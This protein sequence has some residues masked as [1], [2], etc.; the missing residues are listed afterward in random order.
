MEYKEFIK[1]LQKSIFHLYYYLFYNHNPSQLSEF[2]L[3]LLDIIQLFSIN[4]NERVIIIFITY[5]IHIFGMMI[6]KYF[7]IL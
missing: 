5:R 1:Q 3:C 2:L 4:L 6:Q 7:V